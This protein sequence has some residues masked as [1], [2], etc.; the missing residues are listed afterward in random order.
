MDKKTERLL[1]IMHLAPVVPVLVVNSVSEAVATAQALVRGG[2]PAIEVTLRTAD[3]MACIKAI[4][5]DVE[6]A[7]VGA[8]TVLSPALLEQAVLA[9]A[10]FLVSPG[11][12][13]ELIDIADKVD[14]P[15]LPG[16]ATPSEAMGL[17]EMGYHAL[18]F[19][20]AEVAGG[21]PYL[22]ALSGPLPHIK[23]CP[24]GGVT[25]KNASDYLAL[26]NVVCVGGSW[27][28]PS[29]LVEAGEWDKISELARQAASLK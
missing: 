27:V 28:A 29:E 18:K 8:G 10:K 17:G 5:S 6:G 24:T 15:L 14:V 16:V 2:L 11:G 23:F 25:L 22:K 26:S 7:V 4:A 3:A 13:Q 21:V 1:E 19:F 20:P 9:G 12:T